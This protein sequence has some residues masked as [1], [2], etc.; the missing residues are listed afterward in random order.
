MLTIFNLDNFNSRLSFRKKV[1][2]DII[3]VK[4]PLFNSNIASV[5]PGSIWISVGPL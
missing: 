3:L 4:T 1:I 5:L 2:G